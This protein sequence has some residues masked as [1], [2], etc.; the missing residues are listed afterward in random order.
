M[1]KIWLDPGH[2][3]SDSGA[4]N[5]TRYEKYDALNL[6]MEVKR[7]LI[8]QGQEVI[9]T[10][11][12]DVYL[13]LAQ[14]TA[15][16]NNYNSNLSISLHRNASTDAAANGVEIWLHSQ[17]PDSYVIWASGI[18]EGLTALGFVNRGV[19]KGFRTDYMAD[20]AI[21]RDTH[22]PSMLIEVGFITNAGDNAL[23]DPNQD[24]IAASI[25]KASMTFLGLAYSAPAASAATDCS[26]QVNALTIQLKQV[27]DALTTAIQERDAAL[28]KLAS[29]KSI[30]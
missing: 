20:Y 18:L 29:I 3:G 6:A 30:L 13:T 17:A 2:G 5:G 22:S 16:E 11:E 21:N 9:M 28:A 27:T 24:R 25:I 1:A 14:R 26:E 19:K 10:R 8:E 7:Q 23:F 12:S 15:I 4:V